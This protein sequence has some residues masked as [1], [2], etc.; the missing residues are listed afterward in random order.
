MEEETAML[1]KPLTALAEHLLERARGAA[2][3]RSAEPLY[4]GNEHVLR[5]T[6][7]A[8]RAGHRLEEHENPS[9]ATLQ[10]L[11][12]R[13]VLTAG[14]ASWHGWRGDLL[15]IP[16][17]RHSLEAIEDAV[18]LLTVAKLT[19]AAPTRRPEPVAF[20]KPRETP[21]APGPTAETVTLDARVIP[22][23]VRHAA[24]FGALG[25]L[26]AGGALDVLEPHD[27]QRMLAELEQSQPGGF[28]VSYVERG[29]EVWRVRF[30]R[31]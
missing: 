25:A 7:I 5:Q 26:P 22:K 20:G 23:A 19:A 3:G 17:A 15:P 29:P 31:T 27:P 16:A 24:V 2:S 10:V 12:G 18:V 11:E 28:E 14:E 1:K 8:L 30:I 9:E 4:G 6:L 21:D 13:V